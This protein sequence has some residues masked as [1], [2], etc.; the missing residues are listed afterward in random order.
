MEVQDSHDC[1]LIKVRIVPGFD[2]A[3]SK[4]GLLC[5]RE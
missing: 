3:A 5:L 1:H 4:T 2:I